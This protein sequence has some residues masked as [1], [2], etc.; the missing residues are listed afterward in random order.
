MKPGEVRL[1]QGV[2]W[3]DSYWRVMGVY[4]D[5]T[6]LRLTRPTTDANGNTTFNE[7]VFNDVPVEFVSPPESNR[8]GKSAE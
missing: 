7:N 1:G 2:W 5:G 3:A 4:A 8:P 6:L